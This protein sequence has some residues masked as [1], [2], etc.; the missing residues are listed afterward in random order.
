[1]TRNVGRAIA[2]EVWRQKS[3]KW[4]RRGVGGRAAGV[5]EV[6]RRSREWLGGGWVRSSLELLEYFCK[7]FVVEPVDGLV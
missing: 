2:D 5:E 7:P 3:C 4:E 1:M 6:G